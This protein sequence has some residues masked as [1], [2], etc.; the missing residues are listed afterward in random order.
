[1]SRYRDR[2]E[3]GARL[4][5]VL[6]ARGCPAPA[7]LGLVR[8]GVPVAAPIARAL[9]VALDVMV[10]RKLGVPWAPEVAFGALGPGGVRVLNPE[11]AGRID[12]ED[13]ARVSD[14]E[15]VELAR[16]EQVYRPG[17]PPPSLRGHT[18]ILVDDGL[19]TGATAHA[20]VL[21][22]R[23]LGAER[24]V[25]AAPVG[26]PDAIDRIRE[27]AEVVCPL[28]PAEF[29][30]VSR[31]YQEFPQVTDGEVLDLLAAR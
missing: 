18:A 16:R 12:P 17:K 14:T 21:I 8:G 24:V 4:A 2:A 23:D 11:T 27:E 22:A 29:V 19:A 7:V 10:V 1:M 13:I 20:A 28:V 3:A 25:F 15:A 5:E 26:A 6:V 9:G 31:A 30:A